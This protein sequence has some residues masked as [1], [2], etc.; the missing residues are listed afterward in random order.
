MWLGLVFC[1]CGFSLSVSD[2]LSQCLPSNWVFCDLGCGIS[3]HSHL[4]WPWTWGISSRPLA[5]GSTKPQFL[6]MLWF[7]D[8]VPWVLILC[9]QNLPRLPYHDPYN[10]TRLKIRWR[11][12]G[13]H[14]IGLPSGFLCLSLFPLV[15]AVYSTSRM[16][17]GHH[18]SVFSCSFNQAT[19]GARFATRIIL[20]CFLCL[21][22][23]VTDHL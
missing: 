22:Q 14:L 5:L 9:V 11:G 17:H 3:P 8:L 13:L 1:D 7:V 4:S 20:E 18:F 2:A 6:S 12:S 10:E 15:T 23:P 21:S 16:V 19:F